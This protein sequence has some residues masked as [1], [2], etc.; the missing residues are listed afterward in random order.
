MFLRRRDMKNHEKM[1]TPKTGEFLAAMGC[2][3]H[4][5]LLGPGG[6]LAM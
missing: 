1:D 4:R 6:F 2:D 3:G 5:S